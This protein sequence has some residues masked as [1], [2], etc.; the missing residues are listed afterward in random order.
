MKKDASR[1]G[2]AGKEPAGP[3]LVDN[4]EARRRA[5]LAKRRRRTAAGIFLLI[6]LLIVIFRED[7]DLYRLRQRLTAGQEEAVERF[8]VDLDT[9]GTLVWG[10]SRD[11][12]VLCSGSALAVYRQD[13]SEKMSE[14]VS[15][16]NPAIVTADRYALV[17]DRGGVNAYLTGGSALSSAIQS[18][19]T[20][21][22]GDVAEN[23]SFALV[24][25]SSEALSVVEVYSRHGKLRYRFVSSSSYVSGVALSDDGRQLAIAGFAVEQANL[26]GVLRFLDTSSEQPTAEVSLPDELILD[27]GQVGDT[28]MVLTDTALRTYHLKTGELQSETGFD[29]QQLLHY[30]LGEQG[31]ALV[32]GRYTVGHGSSL[33]SYNSS[34]EL[35]GSAALEEDT[36]ALSA[37]HDRLLVLFGGSV[38]LYDRQGN[39]LVT[40]QAASVRGGVMLHGGTAALI[41]G[42][43]VTLL[44]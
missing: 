37:A 26:G 4:R 33:L 28:L 20:I 38:T 10:A 9:N 27:V 35:L 11:N 22:T 13:G 6:A 23:G 30:T 43:G 36:R 18:A 19:G 12:L 34:G 1:R 14:T 7:I 2:S 42:S 17:Y 32:L 31:A 21:L 16:A 44:S 8:T 25:T 29:G 40:R 39:V 5:R 41:D 15:L 24:S 3:V